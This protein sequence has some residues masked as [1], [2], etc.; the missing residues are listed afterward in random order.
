MSHWERADSGATEGATWC[1]R[2]SR[3]STRRAASLAFSGRWCG[4]ALVLRAYGLFL[5][6]SGRVCSGPYIVPPHNACG[7]VCGT[8][9]DE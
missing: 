1:S 4:A 8:D 3:T 2:G 5:D 7:R 9:Y 6:A